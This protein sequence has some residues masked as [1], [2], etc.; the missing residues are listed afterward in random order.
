MSFNIKAM[1]V[2]G[3]IMWGGV[4]L[5]M[6]LANLMFPTYGVVFL[7]FG[8]SI[9]PGYTAQAGFGSVIVATLYALVDGVICGAVFGWLYN[10]V[11]GRLTAA[12]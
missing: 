1:A 12:T 5:L 7:E 8:D 2:V 3:G 6:G 10:M 9:Y 11:A 4:F